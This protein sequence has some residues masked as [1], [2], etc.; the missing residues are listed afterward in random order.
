MAS[1]AQAKFSFTIQGMPQNT[2]HVVRFTGEEGLS[3][4]YRFEIVLFAGDKEVDFE[5]ALANTATFTIKRSQGDIPFHGILERFE[6]LSQSGPYAFY[7][8]VL[9]P[10]AWWLTQT[11]HNQV[12]LD[13]NI[14]QFL[15]AV[16]K[17]GGLN[18][19]LDF[20][21]SLQS[22][23]P[24]WDYLCQY[25]E[26]HFEFASRWMERDGLY[27]FFEQGDTGE[28]LVVTD[29]LTAHGPMPQGESFRYSP[30]SSMQ[31]GHEEEVV[32]DLILTQRRLPQKVQLRDYNYQTPSLELTA[33][34]EV[35]QNGQG[36]H[37][38]YGLHFLNTSQGK[39]LAQ[40]RVQEFKCREKVFTGVSSIPFVRPGYTF[41]VDNHYR[42]SFNQ[43]YQTIACTHEGSQ[44]AWLVSGLGLSFGK[45]RDALLFY[46]NSFTAIPASVQFRAEL[47]TDR[48]KIAGTLSAKVDAAGSGKYAEVDSQ[49]RYKIILPFD[50]SGR[51][52]GHASAW[53]RM[54]QPYA[55][56]GFGMHMPLHKG[57]EVL[58]SFEGGDPDRPVISNAVPNPETASPV[59]D[60]SQTQARI[61]TSG[62]NLIHFEDQDGNQ[63]ILLSSPTQ[64]TF[65]RIGS[66]NDPDDSGGEPET[67]TEQALSPDGLKLYTGGPLTIKAQESFEMIL[68]NKNDIVVGLETGTTLGAKIDTVLGGLVEYQFPSKLAYSS[69]EMH[70]KGE[71]EKDYATKTELGAEKN[72]ITAAY[73][74]MVDQKTKVVSDNV[75][76]LFDGIRLANTKIDT[77]TNR[78]DTCATKQE[79]AGQKD[80]I[81]ADYNQAIANKTAT[82]ASKEEVLAAKNEVSGEVEQVRGTLNLQAGS[83]QRMSGDIT[84]LSTNVSVLAAAVEYI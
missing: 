66:H 51:K 64:Q 35:S 25:G 12:F 22:S 49:G 69:A 67:N 53:V 3:R 13:Q 28:K 18:P 37:Y 11:T 30:P 79:L 44:E 26:T 65:V 21:M 83:I 38:L 36:V 47:A 17:D 23:Y 14:E 58:V 56:A 6:Q 62:G 2:F 52:D 43:S 33:E 19:G 16:F 78:V 41:K 7:R 61:T 60:Q 4:L 34:E 48:P 50:L 82:L 84:D 68:G 57:C 81:A 59:T 8:A 15:T 46:R 54:A 10:K 72:T 32:T 45:E 31:V 63:R 73:T 9:V 80:T 71:I 1:N 24:T 77:I 20:K 70:L 42:D 74:Q 39:A 5:K 75:D 55:G 29:T 40:I 27:Y 76:I